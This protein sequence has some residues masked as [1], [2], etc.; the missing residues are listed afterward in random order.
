MK[1][2]VYNKKLPINNENFANVM[3]NIIQDVVVIN[4]LYGDIIR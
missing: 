1:Y 3:V 2:S 4:N